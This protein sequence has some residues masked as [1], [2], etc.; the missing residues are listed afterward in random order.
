MRLILL[1]LLALL[2][3]LVLPADSAPFAPAA[4]ERRDWAAFFHDRQTT[5]TIVVADWR[6]G[7]R[8]LYACNPARAAERFT[9][10]STF[11]I[12]HSLFALEGGVVRDEF[13]V[14]PWDGEKR[15]LDT[16]NRD[17][18]LRSS[19]RN[20]VVWVYERIARE[21]GEERERE[22]LARLAYGNQTIG[23]KVDAF[24]LDDSLRINAHEQVR[25]LQGL[26]R[27]DLPFRIEN[28][29]LVKDIIVVEAGRDWILR[30]KTGWS[31]P[32]GWWV[33]WV[34]WPA[35]PV[36]FALNIDTPNRMDDLPKREAITRAILQSM[37]ALPGKH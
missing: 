13:Q 6:G 14:F 36:F 1:L 3:P 30:A 26:Y 24:W 31:G 23:G 27:N 18:D 35:G 16:W 2:H 25:F 33:G 15:W 22:Y 8:R 32:M 11:K 29:R 4:E 7:D 20:S 5:G 17:H 9:P 12:P 21:L 37:D 19:M 28:Q 10:A 34:E